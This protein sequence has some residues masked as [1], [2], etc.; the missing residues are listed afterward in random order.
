MRVQ[1]QIYFII[2]YKKNVNEI[3]KNNI[4]WNKI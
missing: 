3:L 1:W 4:K 2:E